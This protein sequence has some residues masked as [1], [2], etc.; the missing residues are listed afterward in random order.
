MYQPPQFRE[1][2]RETQH[3]FIRTHPLGLLVTTGASGIEANPI[4]FLIKTGVGGDVL[5]AHLARANP[6]IEALSAA[7]EA[8]VVFQGTESYITPS[9]YAEK[10]KHGKVVPTW[11]Y[12]IVQVRGRPRVIADSDWLRTQI[13]ELTDAQES[14][15]PEPWAVSDAPDDFVERQIKGIVGLEITVTAIDAKWKVS[16]NRP[17]ADR[18][19][20]AAG[21]APDNIDMAGLV[22]AHIPDED[23]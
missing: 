10:Q 6:Q 15:R 12:V 22:R 5:Q 4:P 23:T 8:L 18:E 21:L 9:W 19:G 1:E 16:Q 3:A 7:D 2:N 17:V 14:P 20:V 13:T 11:N